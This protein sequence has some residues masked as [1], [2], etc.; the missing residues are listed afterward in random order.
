MRKLVANLLLSVAFH[1][2]LCKAGMV[3]ALPLMSAIIVG[4]I[5]NSARGKAKL[6][7]FIILPL[8]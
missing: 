4:V 8:F 5:N 2:A 3:Q 7:F 6:F 1:Q